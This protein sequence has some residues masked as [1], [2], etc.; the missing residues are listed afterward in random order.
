VIYGY[1]AFYSIARAQLQASTGWSGD[2]STD[3]FANSA[4]A[5]GVWHCTQMDC[6]VYSAA[7]YLNR[8]HERLNQTHE[9]DNLGRYETVGTPHHD[10]VT[11]PGCG[12]VP[13]HIA[14]DFNGPRNIIMSAMYTHGFAYTWQWWGNSQPQH[15]C[16]GSYTSADGWVGWSN[17]G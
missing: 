6:E 15:Q 12:A 9:Q 17:I 8:Y 3:Q 1:T 2:N 13:K 7:E 10:T 14:D 16:N 4:G 11:W 5:D